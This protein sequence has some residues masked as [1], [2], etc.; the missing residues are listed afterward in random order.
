MHDSTY[1]VFQDGSVHEGV[2]FGAEADGLG[3]V[4]F[5]TSMTGYQEVL[6]DPSYAGQ[7]VTLTYPLV[8]NY[9]INPEDFESDRIQVGGLIVRE[10][11]EL[12][13]HGRSDLTLHEFLAGQGIPGIAEVDTRSI[14]RQIRSQGVMLG[15]ITNGDPDV[16]LRRLQDSPPYGHRDYVATVTTPD[17]YN[18]DGDN[19]DLIEAKH[20]I[21]V[22]DCG[23]KYN[24]L[25][26]LRRRG[27]RVT[28]VPA[29]TPAEE[30]LAME[31]SGVLFSPGPG[32]PK[33]LEYVVD[34]TRKVLGQVPVMGI[35]LGHQII[36][37]ALG[38]DT[39][40]LKFGHRGGN[41][42]VKDLD[43]GRVY[44]TAQNHGYA[45]SPDNLPS[46]LEVSHINL[47]DQ[48]VEG[49]RHK[50]LPLFT[51]QYHSEA[52]PGPRD[53]EYLF[54]QFIDMVEDFHG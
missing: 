6:T 22:T 40:K 15:I 11:C 35:C 21:L 48:T 20:R 38:A 32:D 46:G 2:S 29:S 3:E 1:L 42:P 5:N 51:I 4:V 44:I 24:I 17:G 34:N 28:V 25:R 37:R 43:D 47:N 39:F 54:D 14:T 26:Q 23:L 30:L 45:V 10:N 50:S 12:P 36:A 31:P 9:G 27:C 13:S 18:W 7:L 41:H 33:L 49:F 16:A 19:E 53:N 52:S 8:G